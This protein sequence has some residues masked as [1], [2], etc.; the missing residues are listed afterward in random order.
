MTKIM[1]VEDDRTMV[2]LL[3]TLLSLEGYSVT[4]PH[5]HNHEDVMAAFSRERPEVALVDVNLR[6]GNGLDLVRQIRQAPDVKDTRIL[7]CS[8]MNLKQ[9]CLQAGADG[10]VLKPFMPDDLINQIRSTLKQDNHKE[11]KE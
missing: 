3:T 4:T 2:S 8:G 11:E 7:M 6:T 10:F 5:N 9:E 1:L